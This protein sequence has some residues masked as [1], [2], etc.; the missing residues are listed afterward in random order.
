MR[1]PIYSS[2]HKSLSQSAFTSS[3]YRTFNNARV[4][5]LSSSRVLKPSTAQRL[6]LRGPDISDSRCVCQRIPPD[7]LTGRS[8]SV[9]FVAS[10][11]ATVLRSRATDDTVAGFAGTRAR[12]RLR[13]YALSNIAR[14]TKLIICALRSIL[15]LAAAPGCQR[16]VDS[17]DGRRRSI[18]NS[19]RLSS[20]RARC[21]RAYVRNE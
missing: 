12:V 3:S 6:T 4:C 9:A 10:W 18:P 11:G 13:K 15:V 2:R 8:S 21:K 1:R 19:R 17:G 16:R 7:V 20:N 14:P 5:I